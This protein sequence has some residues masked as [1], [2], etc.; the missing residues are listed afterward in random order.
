MIPEAKRAVFLDRDGVL[1]EVFVIDGVPHPPAN[2]KQLRVL[3]G[4]ADALDRLRSAGWELVVVTNQPDV[5]RGV[6]TRRG[7]EAI[8]GRLREA[9]PL[10]EIVVCYHDNAD[11]CL[12]RKPKPGML[13]DAAAR[14]GI[15]LNRSFMVG[16]RWSDVVAGSAAGCRTCLIEKPYSQAHKCRCD[17]AVE[18]LPRAAE[19]IMKC[20]L[21]PDDEIC[22]ERH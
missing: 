20:L 1:N 9:L 12:C 5:A 16:D 14:R 7:V 6:Q 13:I 21:R 11:G 17:Y 3:P 19:V 2:A 4:V 22:D 15:S 8:N 10:D 18:D